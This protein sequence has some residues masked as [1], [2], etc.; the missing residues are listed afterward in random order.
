[1]QITY[2][3]SDSATVNDNVFSLR[4]WS[5][6]AAERS[7]LLLMLSSLLLLLFPSC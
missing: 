6:T 5:S 7:T 1:M 2:I 3:F 4:W